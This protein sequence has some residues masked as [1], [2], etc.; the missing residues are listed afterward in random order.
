VWFFDLELIQNL[1]SS[2]YGGKKHK[3]AD[4]QSDGKAF[5]ARFD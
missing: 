4:Y 1:Q 5:L 3:V 2:D